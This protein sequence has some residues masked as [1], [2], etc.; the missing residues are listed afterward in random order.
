VDIFLGGS[1]PCRYCGHDAVPRHKRKDAQPPVFVWVPAWGGPYGLRDSPVVRRD[2]VLTRVR[3]IG[4][5][6]SLTVRF[7]RKDYVALLD[8]WRPPPPID[9]VEAA[10]S[11]MIGKRV[12][13]LGEVEVGSA[14]PLPRPDPTGY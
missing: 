1:R 12:G 2:G 4:H 11:T 7:D 13:R 9:A 10:L 8:E 5:R 3:R 6:L 14:V